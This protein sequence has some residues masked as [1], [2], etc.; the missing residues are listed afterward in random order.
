MPHRFDT[1]KKNHL[2]SEERH[3]ALQPEQ[4]LRSLGLKE[5]DTLADIGCGP[6]FFTL[7][8]AE[9][10]GAAG[11]V[12]AA[13][14]QG[15]MLS[16]VRSRVAEK[17]YTNVHVMKSSE[18]DVPLPPDSVDVVLLAFVLN[19]VEH[20]SSFLHRM[21]RLLKPE[22]RVAVLE[23][24]KHEQPEGPPVEDRV[25]ADELI[26]DAMAAGLKLE[27]RREL[28][29]HQYLCTFVSTGR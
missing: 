22:G 13:D 21:A 4:L 20:R 23:W 7:P 3:E 2:L 16:T 6:G 1:R 18:L 19:E 10:V 25:S 24:E 5:G 17:G 9:I 29:E 27:E 11:L 14:V 12:I 15:E 8:A 28:S 26:A